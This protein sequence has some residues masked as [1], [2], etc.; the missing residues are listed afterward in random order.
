M[1]FPAIIA[2]IAKFIV[3]RIGGARLYE[4]VAM[5]FA[6]GMAAATGP[7]VI[8]GFMYQISTTLATM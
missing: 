2:Y 8:L 1:M 6:I 5:P 4:D 7:A 3:M